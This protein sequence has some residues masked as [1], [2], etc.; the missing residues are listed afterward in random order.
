MSKFP[1]DPIILEKRGAIPGLI[2]QLSYQD[3]TKAIEF[4]RVW[5]E[6]RMPIT[7]LFAVLNEELQKVGVTQ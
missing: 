5:G 1:I 4:L 6:K 2:A 3:E 7:P